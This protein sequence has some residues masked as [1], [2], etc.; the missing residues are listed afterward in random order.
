LP[1]ENRRNINLLQIEI[2]AATGLLQND[3]YGHELVLFCLLYL[4]FTAVC[5]FFIFTKSVSGF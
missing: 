1:D 4:V 2:T 5:L 3:A